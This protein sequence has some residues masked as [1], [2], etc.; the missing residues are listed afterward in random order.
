MRVGEMLDAAINLYRLHWKAFMAIVAFVT[1]PF[2]FLQYLLS[3]LIVG[4]STSGITGNAAVTD[5][6]AA[7]LAAVAFG[8]VALDYFLI[9]PFLTAAIVRAVAGAYLGAIPAVG[10]IYRFALGRLG[11]ILWVVTLTVLGV[12]CVFLA[13]FGFSVLFATA[14]AGPLIVVVM[15]AAAVLAAILFVRWMFGPSIV[16]VEDSRGREALSRSWRV[17]GGA[18]WKIVGTT[19]LASLLTGLV[20]GVFGIIPALLSQALGSSGWLLRAAGSALASVITTPFA[21]IVT[22][23]L[24]FDQRIRKEGLD[25]AIMAGEIGQTQGREVGRAS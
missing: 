8:F 11:S 2:V 14:G 12:A 16:I 1:V 23:L 4:G 5:S 10:P 19:L 13:G 24:Y 17:S 20:G 3:A 9:R 6:R 25:L 7:S 21:T 18:F 15:I 22:V